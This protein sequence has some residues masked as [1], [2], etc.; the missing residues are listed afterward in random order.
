MGIFGS[1]KYRY[2]MERQ[3]AEAGLPHFRSQRSK[4]GEGYR[5]TLALADAAQHEKAQA[6]L[7]AAGVVYTIQG[8]SLVALFHFEAEAQRALQK[9]SE[10]DLNGGYAKTRGELPLWVV[11]AGPFPLDTAKQVRQQLAILGL[12]SYLRKAP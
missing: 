6:T 11:Y 1:Q 9:L 7:D 12:P 2:A 10:D 8:D 4:Q 5:L 3:L